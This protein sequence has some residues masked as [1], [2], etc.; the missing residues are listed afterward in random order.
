MVDSNRRDSVDT[1]IRSFSAKVNYSEWLVRLS[2][3]ELAVSIP[4]MISDD[5]AWKGYLWDLKGLKYWWEL[6]MSIF[7]PHLQNYPTKI[8]ISSQQLEKT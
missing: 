5:G 2:C 1:T 4:P 6:F 8:N 3:I 7:Y